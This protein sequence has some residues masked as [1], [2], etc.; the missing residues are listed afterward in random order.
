MSTKKLFLISSLI[1]IITSICATVEGAINGQLWENEPSASQNVI[2]ENIPTR[3]ADVVFTVPDGALDFD[4]DRTSYTIGGFLAS[5]GATIVSGASHA[6]DSLDSIVVLFTG[7]VSVTDGNTISVDHDDGFTLQIGSDYVVSAPGPEST[8]TTTATYS[9]PSGNFPFKLFY[10][11][12]CSPPAILGVNLPLT[13]TI[14]S[15]TK[16]DDVNDGD[17][18]GS[19]RQITYTIDY[20]YPKDS[21]IGDINDVN[22]ID[23]LPP[24]VNFISDSNGGVYSSGSRTVTWSIGTLHPGDKGSV[25]LTVEVNSPEPGDT[26]TNECVI[27]SG[28]QVLNSAYEYTPVCW[29]IIY[30]DADANGSNNGTSWKDAYNYLQDALQDANTSPGYEEIWVAEGKYR[31]DINSAHPNGT[32]DRQATFHLVNK[33]AIYGGFPAGGGEWENRKP[34]V[35]ETILSGDL[36][37]NDRQ[38][39]EPCDLLND[40]CRADNSFHVV[41]SGTGITQTTILDGF[42]IT[43]GDANGSSPYDTGGGMYNGNGSPIVTNCIFTENTAD[44]NGGGMYNKGSNPKITNCIFSENLAGYGGGIY[45]FNSSPKITNCTF[46]GNTATADANGGGIYNNSSSPMIINCILWGNVALTPNGSQVSNYNNSSPVIAYSDIQGGWSPPPW[47]PNTDPNLLFNMNFNDGYYDNDAHTTTS[48]KPAPPN[49]VVGTL[50]DY[51]N[52]YPNVFGETSAAG[53]GKDANFAAMHDN[54]PG[55]GVASSIPTP[56]D[57]RVTVP[58]I[59]LPSGAG[60]F[61][62]GD[63]YTDDPN[64]TWAFWFNVPYLDQGTMIRHAD[65]HLEYADHTNLA[66]EIRI[67]SNKLQFYHKNNCLGMETASS[68]SDLGVTVNTW[69]HAALVIDRSNCAPIIDRSNCAP[70]SEPTT[71]LS[72][73]IYID[74]LEVPIIVNYVNANNM[75]VDLYYSE[76]PSPLW[77]GA[78]EREFEGL[79][80]DVRL[81]KE[82]L[83]PSQVSILSGAYNINADPCFV[84]PAKGN[85]RLLPNSPCIDAGNNSAVPA[86]IPDLDGDGNTAESIPFDIAGN[87]RIADGNCDGQVTVD[88]GA[89]ER[90][91]LSADFT[92][93]CI[94][95]F[96]DFAIMGQE[97]LTSGIKTDI[98][99]DENNLVDLM[100]LVVLAEE[101]LKEW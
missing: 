96:A 4:S 98:Y 94:V 28:E 6:C 21:N 14:I 41:S 56:N 101:W 31:P 99:K 5:G 59:T 43:A 3:P 73:K 76:Y 64:R 71:Q 39:A 74:G 35:Y 23:H 92:C 24:E 84:N 7:H 51:N 88:M 26:I 53:L 87:P 47:N 9:G 20:N 77:I 85:Y 54:A 86:D 90:C 97:W 58:N 33:V 75:N 79:L 37:R 70:T 83:T 60:I 61:D 11:E 50:V 89:Y 16:L 65:A 63:G 29:R 15:L 22:I 52:T 68:L 69:H 36:L 91:G 27:K 57:V 80:D 45:D 95:N 72:S 13:G 38:V 10:G 25:T 81:Y 93:D 2:F 78:G 30:V 44:A 17:C 48:A 19:G 8:G 62:F 32:G 34:S 42:T 12:C 46:T 49:A 82:D 18:V 1:I 55:P 66:W 40:P 67:Y 100:D